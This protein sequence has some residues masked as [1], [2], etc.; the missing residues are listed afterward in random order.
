MAAKSIELRLRIDQDQI[1]HRGPNAQSRRR[2][3]PQEV[4]HVPDVQIPILRHEPPHQPLHTPILQCDLSGSGV[5][6]LAGAQ[7][8]LF[9]VE[10]KVQP[11]GEGVCEL[12]D[13]DGG[14]DGG[15]AG[16]VGDGGAEDEGDG[17]VDGD[18]CDPEEFAVF[19]GEG[20]GAEEFDA[21]VI[22]EDC[23]GGLSIS[24]SSG[25]IMAGAKSLPLT[26]ILPYKPAA[27]RAVTMAKTLPAVCQLYGEIPR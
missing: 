17:P 15:E 6:P 26:P 24:K 2:Q 13:A 16:E 27:I 4:H 14:H 3:R 1:L 25:S 23:D 22:V 12:D 11:G 7:G 19:K 18:Q 5:E 8:V 20:W 10:G 21:D 9:D